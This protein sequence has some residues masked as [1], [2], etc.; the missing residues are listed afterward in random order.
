MLVFSRWGGRALAATHK[1]SSTAATNS[2]AS[3]NA[4]L[5]SYWVGDETDSF[6]WAGWTC[7]R[8]GH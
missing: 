1:T 7:A 8:G 6:K 3:E 5:R 2:H 4:S